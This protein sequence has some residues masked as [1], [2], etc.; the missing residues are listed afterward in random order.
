[1]VIVILVVMMMQT[2]MVMVIVMVECSVKS[3]CQVTP[4]IN[5]NGLGKFSSVPVEHAQWLHEVLHDV[6]L[7]A[8]VGR[9]GESSAQ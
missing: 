9:D 1:M 5:R 2:A 8:F 3:Q 7:V 4:R 6:L